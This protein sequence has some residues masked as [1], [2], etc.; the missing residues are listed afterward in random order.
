MVEFDSGGGNDDHLSID[1]Q[2]NGNEQ[3]NV[4]GNTIYYEGMAIGTIDSINNGQNGANLK[5]TFDKNNP[6]ETE[7]VRAQIESLRY[8]NTSG[9]PTGTRT[10][11]ISIND[12]EASSNQP[13]VTIT[14]TPENDP[15]IIHAPSSAS[16]PEGEDLSLSSVQISDEDDP[17]SEIV[18]TITNTSSIGLLSISD[19]YTSLIVEG[20]NHSSAMTFKA[21]AS[22]INDTLKTLTFP[23]SEGMGDSSTTITYEAYDPGDD[24][25]P[26][27]F[28]ATTIEIKKQSSITQ[29]P[30][31]GQGPSDDHPSQPV[32][33]P[34][35]QSSPQQTVLHPFSM[36][37]EDIPLTDSSDLNSG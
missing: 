16:V 21:T 15:P 34:L 18:V 35:S 37:T 27:G 4:S 7:T 23:T 33:D 22:E 6:V 31:D 19:A 9:H 36:A 1:N 28:A 24:P 26:Q 29:L 25:G 8:D 11:S 10:I 32:E 30:Q 5:I 3:T 12:G 13:T 20:E 2:G 17:A 14:V